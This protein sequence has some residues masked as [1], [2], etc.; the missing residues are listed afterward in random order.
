MKF[1]AKSHS[2]LGLGLAS[3]LLL[4]SLPVF[5]HKSSDENVDNE[6]FEAPRRCI[7]YVGNL[8]ATIIRRT[9]LE[10]VLIKQFFYFFLHAQA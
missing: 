10:H 2:N 3:E 7:G 1:E 4:S 5:L 8:N 6:S 9:K